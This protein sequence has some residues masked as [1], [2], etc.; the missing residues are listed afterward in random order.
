[1]KTYKFITENT[2]G[3]NKRVP[4]LAISENAIETLNDSD[5]YDNNYG[6]I[7]SAYNAGDAI[8]LKSENAVEVADKIA[9][10][11]ELEETFE[12]GSFI[13]AFDKY[14]KLAKCCCDNLK[15]LYC[16]LEILSS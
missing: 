10:E 13:S 16:L 15:C 12:I 3:E 6:K 8:K 7:V 11:L 14:P 9:H 2:F 1:M 5:T 4:F